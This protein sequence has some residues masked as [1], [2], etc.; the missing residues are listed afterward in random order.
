MKITWLGHASFLIETADGTR[1]VTDPFE[2]GSYGG[3]VGY[4]PI[5]ERADLVTVSHEHPDHNFVEA[6]SG[7]PEV[8]RDTG[9]R[10]VKGIVVR[11]VASYHDESRGRERGKNTIYV[12]EADG[13]KVAHLGDLGHTLSAE[14]ARALGPVDVLLAPVGGHFTIGPEDAK[15][16]A[17]RLGAKVVIPM[18]YKTDL[19][20]FPIRP[21]DDFLRLMR[22]VERPG[23]R[24]IE[25]APADARGELK[26]VVLDYK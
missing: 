18:H 21:V 6:V 3:A 25:I 24:A 19:L 2:A 20:G 12:F 1:V 16:V 26:V 10:T 7:N 4:A 11:G 22:R 9:E 17:E 5:E 23:R 13:L 8:V 14:E 15:R